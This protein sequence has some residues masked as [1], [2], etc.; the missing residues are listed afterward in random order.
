MSLARATSGTCGTILSIGLEKNVKG[1]IHML[2][3]VAVVAVAALAALYDALRKINA[4]ILMQVEQND[5]I[6]KL[7]EN[8]QKRHSY[9]SPRV[10]ENLPGLL[11][12]AVFFALFCP[13]RNR[14]KCVIFFANCFEM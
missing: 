6:I 13:F 7:L 1:A 3:L 14:T 10:K 4:N 9:Y 8:I 11:A 5:R 12:A 2:G